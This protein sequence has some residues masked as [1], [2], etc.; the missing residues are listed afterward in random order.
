MKNE[1]KKLPGSQVEVQVKLEDKEFAGYYQAAEDE[2]AAN[3]T[4]KGFRKGTAPKEMVAAALDHDKIFHTAINE[5]VRWSL[6]EIKREHMWTF[7]DQPRIE[8]TDGEPG[9]GISYKATLT[10]FPEIELGD[11]KKI[12]AKIFGEQKKIEISEDEVSKTVEW[13]RGSRAVETRVAR[14]AQSKD[15]VEIDIET[16]S[17]GV[18]VP[19]SSFQHE[20]FILGESSFITGFDKHLEGKKENEVVKFSITAP[21]E[22]WEKELRGKQLDFT[23]VIH[24]VFERTLPELNDE[25]VAKLGPAFKTVEDLKKNIREGLTAEKQEKENEKLRIKALEAIAKD[26]K[27]DIPAILIER[28]LDSMVADLDRMLPPG[29]NKNPEALKKEMREKFRERATSN[30][31]SN[32]VMYKLAG[33]EKLEPTAEELGAEAIKMGVDIEKEHD[34]IYGTLQNK[35]VFEFLEAQAKKS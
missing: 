15:L 3:V 1:I 11:Y 4:L 34:Y 30:V 5:A 35:K 28:T 21:E 32:L 14:G 31:S 9:K 22:Y 24:G 18:P 27:M 8:V 2:A 13:I 7:I 10:L 23:V 19:N 20:R 12:A 16:E 17:G 26:S 6:D 29:E 25:F 33:V